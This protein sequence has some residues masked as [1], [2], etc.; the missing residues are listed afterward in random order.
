MDDLFEDKNKSWARDE[1]L[2]KNFD[3]EGS[4]DLDD[5]KLGSAQDRS[6]HKRAGVGS[7]LT[8]QVQQ[9]LNYNPGSLKSLS[10][11]AN[12]A[13]SNSVSKPSLLTTMTYNEVERNAGEN[14]GGDSRFKQGSK[15]KAMEG[16]CGGSK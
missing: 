12:I 16:K 4:I 15:A 14:Y 5:F 11:H 7:N 6:G 13:I 2:K 3:L 9:S 10:N 1:A 8:T